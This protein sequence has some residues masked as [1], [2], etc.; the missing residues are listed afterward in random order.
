MFPEQLLV[1]P[2]SLSSTVRQSNEHAREE[3]MADAYFQPEAQAYPTTGGG[4]AF[5]DSV[6][7]AVSVPD[8]Q[9]NVCIG[10]SSIVYAADLQAGTQMIF[11]PDDFSNTYVVTH[12]TNPG[13]Y[14]STSG[15]PFANDLIN[16]T[17]ILPA[18]SNKDTQAA[19]AAS[20][21]DVVQIASNGDIYYIAGGI[22]NYQVA[23]GA[24]W[25]KMGYSLTGLGGSNSTEGGA[26][27]SSSASSG[28]S[29]TGSASGGASSTASGSGSA[30]SGGASATQSPNAAGVAAGLRFDVAGAVLGMVTLGML[31][32]L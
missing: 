28:A 32:V 26:S 3:L 15:A 16:S 25:T 17:Q 6:G 19:Y 21:S 2:I 27:S 13:D 24:S 22:A 20:P 29:S 7:Q 5:P 18:P 9:N 23:S 12:W 14:S 8:S 10:K 1:Q 11:V 31:Y 4:S 30:A